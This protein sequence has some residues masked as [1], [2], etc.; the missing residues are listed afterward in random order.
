[1][2]ICIELRLG[3]PLPGFFDVAVA[4][5][6]RARLWWAQ[7]EE[8]MEKLGGREGTETRVGGITWISDVFTTASLIFLK[9][10]KYVF[11]SGARP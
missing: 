11:C 5:R 7:Q 1:M 2:Q 8:R 9:R 3:P 4:A 6:A 10:S